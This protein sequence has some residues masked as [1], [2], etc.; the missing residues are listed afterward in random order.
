M[1]PDAQENSEAW[2]I[3]QK[4]TELHT[5]TEAASIPFVCFLLFALLILFSFLLFH[6]PMLVFFL[7]PFH[8]SFLSQPSLVSLILLRPRR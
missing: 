7:V 1:R 8:V 2:Q 6:S 5:I 4:I 3:P